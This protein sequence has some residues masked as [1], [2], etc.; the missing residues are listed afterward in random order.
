MVYI[1]TKDKAKFIVILRFLSIANLTMQPI[2]VDDQKSSKGLEFIYCLLS[3]MLCVELQGET[4][5]RT[6]LWSVSRPGDNSLICRV[7]MITSPWG[8]R[9][10]S[11]ISSQSHLLCYTLKLR[12]KRKRG[13]WSEEAGNWL[14]WLWRRSRL[15][16]FTWDLRNVETK[17]GFVLVHRSQFLE[18]MSQRNKHS[19][20]FQE[21]WGD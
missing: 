16:E 13:V 9:I 4:S 14:S 20:T 21:I 2:M 7:L 12:H 3:M 1:S 6:V 5:A 10:L 17:K 8:N 15:N 19:V 11:F 18:W